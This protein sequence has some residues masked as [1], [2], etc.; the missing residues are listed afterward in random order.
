M[1]TVD[2]ALNLLGLFTVATPE[3]GLSD[4]ARA[5]GLDK[6]TALRLLGALLRHGLVEQRSDSRRY[7]LGP[8]LLQLALVREATA[9]VASVLG[10]VVERLA[11]ATGETA[12]ATLCGGGT[13]RTVAIAEGSRT[14]RVVLHP[15]EVLEIHATASG[16][17]FLAFA[18]P[19]EAEAA[20]AACG[21]ARF[22]PRTPATREAVE[23]LVARAR[24]RGWALADQ[25]F[26]EEVV[27]IAAP[28]FDATGRA[29]GAV[30]VASPASRIDRAAEAR[31]ARL[32]VAAALEATAGLGGRASA[33]F[34][35]ATG[36]E[37]A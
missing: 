13:L 17:A 5:A 11:A 20:L 25:T 4:I 26:E 32:V 30:A 7:R 23:A 29:A 28:F 35:A 3:R 27:G 18:A 22:T 37:A 21:F 10:P 34:L 24:G 36:A 14:T 16:L 9:P 6:A 15:S 8:A 19:E 2:K 1:K 33:A 31:I 12:H